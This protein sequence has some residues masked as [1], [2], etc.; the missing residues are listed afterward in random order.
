LLLLDLDKFK[1]VND[2]QGHHAGDQLLVEVG[3]RLRGQ[4]RGGDLLARLGGDEF[5]VL[6]EDAGYDEAATLAESLHATLAEPF[7][8]LTG[9]FSAGT[10]TLHTNASIGIALYPDDSLDLDALLHRADIAMYLAKTSG[11]GHHAY[12][13]VD[14]AGAAT[15]Q[16]TVEELRTAL[17]AGQLVL[18]YQPKIDLDTG[19]V[20]SVEALVRWD[21]PTRGLLYPGDF[22]AL[23]EESG[24]MRAV[25]RL[26]LGMALDQAA[27]WQRQG[28]GLS[29]AVNLS[30]SSLADTGLS[31]EILDMLSTRKL[32]TRTLQLEVREEFLMSDHDRARGLLARLRDSGIQ[33]SI[34]NFGTGYTS[35]THLRDL[36]VD[37]LKLDRSFV[38]PMA[39]HA[40]AA[41]LVAS[42]IALAHSLK[43]RMVAEGV[44]TEG[45]YLELARLGC[46]QAQGFFI[47]RPVPATEIEHWLSNRRQVSE[48]AQIPQR[49]SSA[50]SG[51]EAA[52]VKRAH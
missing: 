2:T 22:L 3:A 46:D 15:R 40:S 26:V 17:T 47:S 8:P 36:P 39:E 44:E 31:D 4:M 51:L 35:L 7:T 20:S 29:V 33:I 41:G 23:V 10:V 42:T 49:A 18:H 5:A 38:L 25:T 1:E 30:A 21:H 13:G 9:S 34:D 37:E 48:P 27:E 16:Q 19:Q 52:G 14:D 12:S 43:L 28:L 45:A 6:L 24:L 32:P 11:Q 50:T